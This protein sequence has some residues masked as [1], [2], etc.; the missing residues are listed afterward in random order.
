MA[1]QLKLFR[2]L[3]IPAGN[4][5]DLYE[6]QAMRMAVLHNI[7]IRSYNSML[8]YSGQ[9]KPGTN[10]YIAFLGYCAVAN[11]FLHAHHDQEEEIYFP[12][13][14]SKLGAGRMSSNIAGHDAFRAQFTAFETLIADL[15]SGKAQWDL[16]TFRNAIYA[17]AGSLVKH[18]GE[19]I[20]TLNADVLREHISL[21]ELEQVEN[22]VEKR[23]FE[24]MSIPRDPPLLFINGDAVNGPWFPPIPTPI[25]WLLKYVLW[26]V[27]SAQ[28]QFGCCDKHMRI[29]PEFAA[30]EPEAPKA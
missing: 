2:C 4:I 14:E 25:L 21:E 23:V 15:Q 18:L 1:D 3:P 8:Y 19:E 24:G 11:K 29:K 10:E 22:A 20:G 17:F 6:L 7:V 16:T 12:F 26:H 27:N 28:W 13:L 5:K 9:I 30:Y